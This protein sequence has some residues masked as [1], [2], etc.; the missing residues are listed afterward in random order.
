[1]RFRGIASR[2]TGASPHVWRLYSRA[3]LAARPPLPG[4]VASVHGQCLT[5]TA[6][7]PPWAIRDERST[8][9]PCPQLPLPPTHGSSAPDGSTYSAPSGSLS[10]IT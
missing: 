8:V 2:T 1:M 5:H 4:V 9:F 6:L 7:E 3:R 10:A